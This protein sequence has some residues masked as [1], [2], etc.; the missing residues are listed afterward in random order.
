MNREEILEKSRKSGKDEGLEHA[1]LKGNRLGEYTMSAIVIPIMAFTVLRGEFVALLA[2]AITILAFVFGQCLTVYRFTKRKVHL[3]WIIYTAA[4]A[5][6]C[7]VL[8][9]A[10]SFGFWGFLFGWL[11]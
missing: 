9:L 11:R 10:K 7:I 8:L 3:A 2:V 5:T 6:I 4:G 1:Y